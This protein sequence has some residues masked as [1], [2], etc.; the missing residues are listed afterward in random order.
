MRGGTGH[1]FSGRE[2]NGG[3]KGS[4]LGFFLVALVIRVM[5]QN[6]I[7][8]A[9][10]HGFLG[11]HVVVAVSILFNLLF[12]FTGMFGQNAVEAFFEVEHEADGAFHI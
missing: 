10:G 11:S 7:H 9:V 12:R 1:G 5:R 3:G 4:G 2:R 8:Q 6:F